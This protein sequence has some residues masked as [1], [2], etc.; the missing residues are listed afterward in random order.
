MRALAPKPPPTVPP[1]IRIR[2]WPAVFFVLPRCL[3]TIRPADNP[4]VPQVRERILAANRYNQRLPAQPEELML[5]LLSGLVDRYLALRQPLTA[6]LETWQRN[7][8]NPRR[9]FKDWTTLLEARMELRK[10]QH[11]S[12]EQ[13][14]AIQ[15]WRDE[16]L[17]H[18]EPGSGPTSILRSVSVETLCMDALSA[19]P[20][21]ELRWRRGSSP[22]WPTTASTARRWAPMPSTWCARASTWRGA[23]RTRRASPGRCTC[24][25]SHSSPPAGSTSGWQLPKSWSRSPSTATTPAEAGGPAPARNHTPRARRP[26]RLCGRRCRARPGGGDAA[27]VGSRLLGG[28][29]HDQRRHDRGPLRHG[30]GR[31]QRAVREG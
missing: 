29:L 20:E 4:L 8:L 30:R 25:G 9:P 2:T 7:L 10:L 31:R 11:L 27:V 22:R 15:E 19:L 23:P 5:R 1:R 24:S 17:E 16:R 28:K 6:Q 12:E 3:V 13:L 18:D 14:D 21:D 26:R